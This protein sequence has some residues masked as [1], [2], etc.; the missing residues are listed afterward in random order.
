MQ[1]KKPFDLFLF[2]FCYFLPPPPCQLQLPSL[3]SHFPARLLSVGVGSQAREGMKICILSREHFWHIRRNVQPPA[4]RAAPNQVG[5]IFG[6]IP[7]SPSLSLLLSLSTSLF[8]L[9]FPT[10]PV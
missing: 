6:P 5:W 10:A 1:K 3:L 7:V 4:R 9:L 2:V 8:A